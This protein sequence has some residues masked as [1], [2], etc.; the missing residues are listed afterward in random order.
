MTRQAM[1]LGFWPRLTVVHTSAKAEAQIYIPE[2]N[3]LL[4]LGCAALIMEFRSSSN[5]AAAYGIAVTATMAIT[6]Y[7]F[8]LVSRERLGFSLGKAL[9]FSVCYSGPPAKGEEVVKPLRQF[10]P[11]VDGVRPATYIQLQTAQ[12]RGDMLH[13]AK[14]KMV[15]RHFIEHHSGSNLRLC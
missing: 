6:S 5:L 15:L 1:Q 11:L 3:W 12:D 2:M 14:L 8:F 9:A 4:M 7:L 10:G 13:V